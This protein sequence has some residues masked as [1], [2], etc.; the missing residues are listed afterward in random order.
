[1]RDL[2]VLSQSARFYFWA[3]IAA[4]VGVALFSATQLYLNPVSS[5]WV[6][7]AGLTALTGSF[8]VR[9]PTVS[10]RI[11]VSDAFVFASVLLFGPSTATVIVALDCL[12]MTLW[13]TRS[14]LKGFFNFSATALAIWI[15]SHTFYWLAPISPGGPDLVMTRLLGPLFLL[16]TLYFLVNTLLVAVALGFERRASPWLLWR[17]HFLWLGVNYFAGVSV[18]ALLVSYTRTVDFAAISIILPLLVIAYLTHRS[19]LGRV[20]DAHLHVE[21][22]NELYMSTIE[23]LAM[24]VDAKDQITH[25][26]IR[27]VQVYALGL[28][29][30]LGV[31]QDRQLQAI[32]TA[33]LLHDLGKL[34]IPEHILNKPGK[35]SPAEFDKIKRHADI[36]ANLL[37]SIKFP[38]PVVPIVR[39][40]H[41]NWDGTGYPAGISGADIPL[42]ARI[43]SVVDCFDALTSDR[44]YR[45]RLSTD[46][47]FA[48]ISERRS[49]MYDPLVVDTFVRAYA[50]MAPSAT[51]AGQEARG[52]LYAAEL[53][54]LSDTETPVAL[55]QT[56]ANAS[57]DTPLALCARDM[58]KAIS[59]AAALQVAAQCLRQLTPATVYAL[60]EY[61]SEADLLACRTASGDDQR[62]L[63]GLHI[64][65]GERVTG[66]SA[67]T[68]RTS[69][70]SDASLDL[71]HIASRF[72]PTLRSTISTPLA[73]GD[74]LI[75]VLTAYSI[76]EDAF[77][78]SH[79]HM[80]ERTSAAL[81]NRLSSLRSHPPR[82]QSHSRPINA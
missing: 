53:V 13:G 7:L 82:T 18:A 80:F 38:Y 36:G 27:R 75:G 1:M 50:E 21:Q 17:E 16:A 11:S 57:V 73:Q 69:V 47:A 70:N 49:K 31:S 41:E 39:H 44:P 78:E 77:N 54:A 51:L 34:A 26:H 60:F 5:G 23:A 45:P 14:L 61:D 71:T 2:S 28:A 32:A 72:T 24:A 56:R 42:G 66:W 68:R 22:V 25:G 40:H 10:A 64:R 19:T 9:V 67:A 8:T 30:R 63:D 20:Q 12:V 48:I 62:L 46:E 29:K 15:A 81:L 65:L 76:K 52:I 79:R 33:A 55:T 58:T 35:L 43:L 74:R 6:M 3:V 4:G 37:S 59:V